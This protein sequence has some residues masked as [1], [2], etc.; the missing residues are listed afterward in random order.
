ELLV[1]QLDVLI[2]GHRTETVFAGP[3]VGKAVR[4]TEP[5]APAQRDVTVLVV[6]ARQRDAQWNQAL[7]RRDA[8]PAGRAPDPTF[9]RGVV[10][11]R[12]GVRHR[13]R[14]GRGQPQELTGLDEPGSGHRERGAFRLAMIDAPPKLLRGFF[15]PIEMR[16]YD[17][18]REPQLEVV[19]RA[20]ERGLILDRGARPVTTPR[21]LIALLFQR[22]DRRRHGGNPRVRRLRLLATQGERGNHGGEGDGPHLEV[23]PA[24]HRVERPDGL[25]HV[26]R[27]L[28]VMERGR[29]RRRAEVQL[30]VA[31]GLVPDGLV[32]D[33]RTVDGRRAP[34]HEP[35]ADVP[36][37]HE[38]R[39]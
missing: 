12:G 15:T 27:L 2:D 33:E 38:D 11:G 14:A 17:A 23:P 13:R 22:A 21:Q 29:P 1:P 37:G 3:R 32:A 34:G 30:V 39:A 19:V 25:H 8:G 18:E 9:R 35:G 24:V 16:Q 36:A 26:E 4:L 28:A 7:M 6:F 20:V 31:A 5:E 10:A